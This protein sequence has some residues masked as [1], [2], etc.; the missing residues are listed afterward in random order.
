MVSPLLVKLLVKFAAKKIAK[1][2]R[3]SA[4]T[5]VAGGIGAAGVAAAI[6]PELLE[7]IPE[8]YRGYAI[9]AVAALVALARVR[10]EIAEAIA[11]AKANGE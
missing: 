6:K 1:R 9:L 7:L 5:A 3:K 2:V 4:T 8:Q 10:K 11:E